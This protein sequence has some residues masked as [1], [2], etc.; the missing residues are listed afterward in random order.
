MADFERNLIDIKARAEQKSLR[1]RALS[2]HTYSSIKNR[3]GDKSKRPESPES[4]VAELPK[5]LA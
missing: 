1:E 5:E 3:H 4:L 2:A